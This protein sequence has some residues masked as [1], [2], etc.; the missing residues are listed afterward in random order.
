MNTNNLVFKYEILTGPI[1]NLESEYEIIEHINIKPV[2]PVIITPSLNPDLF[3]YF[4]FVS[5]IISES[6]SKI[7]HL[8]I[9]AREF[10][11]K[12]IICNNIISR[13]NNTGTL[14]IDNNHI[15]IDVKKC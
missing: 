13:I 8:A 4:D 3:L 14:K 6:G 10:N 2:P 11:K 15:I 5:L 7:S 12:I 1:T 9:L